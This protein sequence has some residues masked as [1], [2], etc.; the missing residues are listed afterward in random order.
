[1]KT[2]GAIRELSFDFGP[3]GLEGEVLHHIAEK[4]KLK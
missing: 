2:A 3:C 1:M 4:K